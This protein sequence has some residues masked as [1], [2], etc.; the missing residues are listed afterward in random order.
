[1]SQACVRLLRCGRQAWGDTEIVDQ[2]G[3]R[4]GMQRLTGP[5]AG[6][7]PGLKKAQTEGSPAWA[8][9]ACWRVDDPPEGYFTST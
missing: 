9:R 3:E 6:K 5:S 4:E 8:F 2:L 1:M 7:Q